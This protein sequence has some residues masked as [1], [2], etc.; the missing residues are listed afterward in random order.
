MSLTKKQSNSPDDNINDV[1][2]LCLLLET[3]PPIPRGDILIISI[4]NA[5]MS[6][7]G[8]Q[9]KLLESK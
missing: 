9:Q 6:R 4:W 1:T 3:H 2:S 5:V 8:I 7:V